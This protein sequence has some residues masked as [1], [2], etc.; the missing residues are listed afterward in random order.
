MKDVFSLEAKLYDKIWGRYDY[1]SDVEFL[2]TLFREYGCKGII[3]IGCGT[4]GHSLR[5]SRKGYYVT[6][7]DLSPAMLK[8][9]EEKD[10][11]AKVKFIQGDMRR[12]NK[13]ALEKKFDAAICLG[14]TFSHLLTNRDVGD[15]LDGLRAVLKKNGLFIFKA[16]NAMKIRE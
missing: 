8:I 12:L 4:G 9:A 6:G 2:D 5:L 10:K 15:F 11:D 13:L 3:D 14:Q 1:D 7:V 16:R